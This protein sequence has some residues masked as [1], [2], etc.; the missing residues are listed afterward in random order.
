[1]KASLPTHIRH[2]EARLRRGDPGPAKAVLVGMRVAFK[3]L[4]KWLVINPR[5][6]VSINLSARQLQNP[7]FPQEIVIMLADAE[8]EGASIQLEL[9][10][11]AAMQDF[12]QT[13]RILTELS[14]M[15]IQ[16]SLDDF[17]MQYSSLDYLKRFPVTTIKIDKSFILGIPEDGEGAAITRSII[18][19]GHLLN[20]F[21]V[22]EG[23]E[24]QSQLDFLHLH[25]CDEVQ[26]Y[27]YS[28]PQNS[29]SISALLKTSLVLFPLIPASPIDEIE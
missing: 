13:I 23:V 10:E 3:Q 15:G 14:Q 29:L 17:G 6:R 28:Q 26:G 22:A 25:Q 20:K 4:K 18:S 16:I 24:S 12:D 7:N 5:L 9:T 27:L 2:C 8:L 21:V 11:S 19:V 1:M